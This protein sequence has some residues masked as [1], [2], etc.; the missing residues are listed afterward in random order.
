VNVNVIVSEIVNV[1]DHEMIKRAT[2]SIVATI[3]A[4]H[5]TNTVDLN[6]SND[7]LHHSSF[8][9]IMCHQCIRRRV[10]DRC[11][12]RHHLRVEEAALLR[13]ELR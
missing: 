3:V 8:I 10:V 13:I 11:N 6:H 1:I 9:L 7:F 5:V 2:A 4:I 12:S